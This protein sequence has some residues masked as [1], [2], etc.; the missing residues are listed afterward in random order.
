M[1]FTCSYLRV[2]ASFELLATHLE[3]CPAVRS[4][5]YNKPV[6]I[7]TVI[8]EGAHYTLTTLYSS[9]TYKKTVSFTP[10]SKSPDE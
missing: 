5:S 9:K 1:S 4:Y 8:Q 6:D 7:Y 3:G 10:V 2:S